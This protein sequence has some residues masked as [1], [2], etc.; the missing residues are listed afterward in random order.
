M[1]ADGVDH[2]MLQRYAV[3]FWD[4]DGVIK[5]SVGIKGAAFERLFVPFGPSVAARVRRHHEQH[6]GVSRYEKL[7]LY[8]R[9]AGEV[10]SDA[11]VERYCDLFSEAV[12]Q[13]VIDSDWVPGAREYLDENHGHQAFILLSATP[14]KELEGIVSAVGGAGWFRA[15]HGAPATKADS[16]V[17]SL[18]E[19][20][21]APRDALLIGD[22]DSDHEAAAKTGI[23][24]LLRR[25]ALN[26][27][28][29][30]RH[31]GPACAHFAGA[32]TPGH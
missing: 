26:A 1:T 2:A 20:G 22:S 10:V 8:L 19:L 9:W 13:A 25:T 17:R 21:C 24:F 28:L 23:A 32:S 11:Q 7:R 27:A 16:I 18:V 31:T 3:L 4:F 29:Q 15:I 14:Q 6:G 12:R 5:D 30:A